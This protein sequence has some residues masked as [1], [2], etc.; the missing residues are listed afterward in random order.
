L[1]PSRARGRAGA[2]LAL[3]LL[4]LVLAAPAA[5]PQ[6]SDLDIPIMVQT[7]PSLPGARFTLDGR[8]FVADEHGLALIT[9]N[10]GGTFGLQAPARI[11]LEEG[12]RVE[13]ARWSDDVFDPEREVSVDSFTYLEAGFDTL[14]RV[15]PTFRDGDGNALEPVRSVTLVDDLGVERTHEGGAPLWLRTERVVA[16]GEG[17]RRQPVTYKLGELRVAGGTVPARRGRTVPPP[18]EPGPWAIEL[19]FHDVRIL[20]SDALFG[21]PISGGVMLEGPGAPRPLELDERGR[22]E[23]EDLPPGHYVARVESGLVASE[24]EFI[25]PQQTSV[26]ARVLTTGDAAVVVLVVAVIGLVAVG[27]RRLA[28]RERRPPQAAPGALQRSLTSVGRS[29]QGV[30]RGGDVGIGKLLRPRADRAPQGRKASATGAATADVLTAKLQAL[31]DEIDTAAAALSEV[32]R[33]KEEVEAQLASE[34]AALG[35]LGRDKETIEARLTSERDELR[36]ERDRLV[37]DLDR[38]RDEGRTAEETLAAQLASLGIE[39]ESLRAELEETRSQSQGLASELEAART[40]EAA[41][42][43]A[44]SERDE[45]RAERDLLLEQRDDLRAE[46]MALRVDRDALNDKLKNTLTQLVA[47]DD[48]RSERDDLRAQ[49]DALRAELAAARA[50]KD[51]LNEK[52]R[53]ALGQLVVVEELRAERDALRARGERA[54][55]SQADPLR[56]ALGRLMRAETIRTQREDLQAHVEELTRANARLKARLAELAPEAEA[57]APPQPPPPPQPAAPERPVVRL[58]EGARDREEQPAEPWWRAFIHEADRY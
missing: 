29:L 13:F 24:T 26:R 20:A 12:T 50:D 57:G 52:L 7:V 25:V 2:A 8:A 55:P 23:A 37:A 16:A 1:R 10:E 27:A 33:E 54:E 51:A 28:H 17:L 4:C 30:R 49:R 31:A 6:E 32:R 18:D 36:A 15:T 34:R 46:V 40:A 42:A 3:T 5:R 35:A 44:A 11:R 39:R 38:V 43:R 58:D 22:A 48:A 56:Q 47:A 9:V 14:R 41:A 45:V 21:A 19:S 53:T